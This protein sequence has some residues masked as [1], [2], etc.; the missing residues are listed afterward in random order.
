MP[1]NMPY[2]KVSAIFLKI[3]WKTSPGRPSP[4]KLQ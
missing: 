4:L 3:N 1:Y 2:T